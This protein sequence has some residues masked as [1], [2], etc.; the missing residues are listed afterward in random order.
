[1]T[2]TNFKNNSY[3]DRAYWISKWSGF[4]AGDRIAFQEI[5][6]EYIDRLYVFGTKL[7]NDEELIKD[8]IQDIFIVL[9]N[10][11][12]DMRKPESIDYYLFKSLKRLILKGVDPVL[13]RF[14]KN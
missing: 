7:T 3:K 9:Y 11:N 1:M 2:K 12:V 10:Y 13:R 4:N 8:S 14:A 5:Y 6:S